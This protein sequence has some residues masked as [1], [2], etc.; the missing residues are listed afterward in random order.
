[1][2]AVYTLC[3]ESVLRMCV[4]SLLFVMLSVSNRMVFSFHFVPPD[5]SH[6]QY[7]FSLLH[8]SS[9]CRLRLLLWMLPTCKHTH[10]HTRFDFINAYVCVLAWVCLS[11]SNTSVMGRIY[12]RNRHTNTCAHKYINTAEERATDWHFVWCCWCCCVHTTIYWRQRK[13]RK[14]KTTTTTTPINFN[15]I[16]LQTDTYANNLRR[17]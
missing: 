13:E 16:E 11:T 6:S 12:S 15:S 17:N 14:T 5:R 2:Y 10:T 3:F 4:L 7:I 8:A 9:F 1:M